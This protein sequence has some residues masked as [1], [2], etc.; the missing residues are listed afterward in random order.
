MSWLSPFLL[1]RP[2]LEYEF[3]VNPAAMQIEESAVVVRHRNLAGDLKKSVMKASAPIIRVNSNYFTLEQRNQFSSLV[4]IADSFLSFQT[5]D[6]W[7]VVDERV[8]WLSSTTMRLANSSATR[9]SKILTEMGFPSIINI[10]TPFKLGVVAGE[11]YGEGGYGEGGY[12][13]APEEFDPGTVTYDD[14]TRILTIT[15]PITDPDVA[16]LVSY[17]YTGWLVDLQTFNHRS[18]AGWLDR[19]TYDFQL[20]GA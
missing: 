7:E 16:I 9:L 17:L 14:A 18:Q 19:F 12:G 8:T 13:G 6:D 2:G 1:G 5:R 10:Q 11:G 3:D 20:V 4:G 15:N